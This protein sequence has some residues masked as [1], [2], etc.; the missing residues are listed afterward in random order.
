MSSRRPK[1]DGSITE[2]P[3]GKFKV[4]IEVEPVEDK[5]KW[6]SRTVSSITEARK[7][8]KELERQKTDNQLIQTKRETFKEIVDVYLNELE[9][10]ADVKES[11]RYHY[12]TFLY[13][14]F[15][16]L[17]AT[18][19]QK[20]TA[21]ELD[22]V[23]SDWKKK[24]YCANTIL[25][26]RRAL[27]VLF[28]FAIKEKLISKNPLKDSK[29]VRGVSSKKYLEVITQEE[30]EKIKDVMMVYFRKFLDNDIITSRTL[31][32]PIYMLTYETG[33]RRGEVAGLKWKSVDFDKNIITVESNLVYVCGKGTFE[34][35][36]KTESSFRPVL[37]STAMIGL[38]RCLKETY[39]RLNINSSYVF[40]GQGYKRITPSAIGENF[41]D[42]RK[43]AGI[44]RTITFHD[45]RHTNATILLNKG[46]SPAS[47]RQSR[48]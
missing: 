10:V 1:G 47:P 41:K 9:E 37:I 42:F 25:S 34:T 26:Y 20:I 24:G 6:V 48:R 16:Y 30:H 33:M 23:I 17:E 19:I 8:L 46:A 12:K 44:Q 32:Y 11:T 38:L 45:I 2:L 35:T 14:W 13:K 29:N 39:E 21:K 15:P 5:R 4:R 3:N 36:P 31:M 40:I 7:V 27:S 18:P 22:K 28:S 43:K